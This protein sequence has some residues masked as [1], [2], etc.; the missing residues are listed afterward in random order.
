MNKNKIRE[1]S[2]LFLTGWAEVKV[3]PV[4]N[5]YKEG[6]KTPGII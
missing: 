1:Y 2:L 6:G 4:Q 3:R 5:L